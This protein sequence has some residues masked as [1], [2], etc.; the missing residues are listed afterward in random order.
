MR[1]ISNF[2]AKSGYV[3]KKEITLS[4]TTGLNKESYIDVEASENTENDKVDVQNQILSGVV[5]S[6]NQLTKIV[7]NM[8]DQKQTDTSN[9][10]FKTVDVEIDNI[11]ARIQYI[12]VNNDGV[13]IPNN[14]YLKSL[15][16]DVEKPFFIGTKIILFFNNTIFATIN[17]T[18]TSIPS[19]EM[20][21]N[22][23]IEYVDGA[24]NNMNLQITF[25]PGDTEIED[26]ES[27]KATLHLTLGY[28]DNVI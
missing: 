28:T 6:I 21:I 18:D 25:D 4:S 2:D 22:K 19:Y 15:K 20:N 3:V 5:E 17:I 9:M 26:I 27:A 8:N 12:G 24:S 1:I 13:P 23:Y 7:N 14:T 16:L 11:N 10:I